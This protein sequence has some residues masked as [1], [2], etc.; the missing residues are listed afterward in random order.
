MSRTVEFIIVS[1]WV[2]LLVVCFALIAVVG[3]LALAG[4][5]I[6]PELSKLTGPA[7]GFLFGSIPPLIKDLLVREPK[8]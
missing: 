8:P 4:H 5:P 7:L 6:D 3:Y 2:L 1:G